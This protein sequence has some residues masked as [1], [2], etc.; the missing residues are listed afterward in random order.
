MASKVFLAT[1]FLFNPI[2]GEIVDFHLLGAIPDDL[3]GILMTIIMTM[4]ATLMM[5]KTT[6]LM[7][8]MSMLKIMIMMKMMILKSFVRPGSLAQWNTPE[9]NTR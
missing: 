4:M 8:M 6:T 7:I 9:P 1:F 5:I 3:S 2:F